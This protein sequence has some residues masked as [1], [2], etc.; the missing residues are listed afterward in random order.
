MNNKLDLTTYTVEDFQSDF[1][2]LMARVENG[3]HIAITDGSSTAVIMPYD[4]E[5]VRLYTEHN[6]GP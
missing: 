1:D 6:E 3:E 5:L 2:N 4:E